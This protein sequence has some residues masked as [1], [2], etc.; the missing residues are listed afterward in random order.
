MFFGY[1]LKE[2]F[3]FPFKDAEARKYLLIGGLISIAA[4]FIPIL[5]YFVLFGYSA[6]IAKQVLKGESPHMVPWED[7]SVMFKEGA[8]LFGIR[9]IFTLPIL[10]LAMP[11]IVGGVAMPFIA[12]SM[13]S[14]NV[15]SIIA[16]FTIIML[17]TMC[18]IIPIS[19]P[20]VVVLPAA[21]MHN[22]D[23]NDFAAAF[24]FKEWWPILRAN[25]GGFIIAFGIYYL[26]SMALMI[27][28]QILVATLIFACLMFIII[29]AITI[30][31]TLVMY[32]T[33]AIAYRNGK[34]KLTQNELTP[35][36]L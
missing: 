12:Q 29:P 8:K 6:I 2:I 26:V 32:V 23:N 4:F 1:D 30:Y 19:I 22:V 17:G 20:L 36:T 27:V 28:M 3:T 25:L 16:I 18:I 5:P 15:D 10:L 14:G 31:I 13:D 9:M 34:E 11:L 33:S 7:W 35:Q 24:R 21:E